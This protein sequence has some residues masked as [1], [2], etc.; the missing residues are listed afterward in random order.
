LDP[1]PEVG[2]GKS[3]KEG[4]KRRHK[5][6]NNLFVKTEIIEHKSI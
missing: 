1:D 6:N 3:Y 4:E 5:T 2:T